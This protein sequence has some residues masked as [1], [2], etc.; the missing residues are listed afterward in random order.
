VAHDASGLKEEIRRMGRGLGFDAVGF[1]PPVLPASA[2]NLPDWLEKGYQAGMGYM[3]RHKDVCLDPQAFFPGVRTVIAVALNYFTPGDGTAPPAGHPAISRYA[4]GRD[5]H[6]VLKTK[7][8]AFLERIREA[9]PG[10]N[11]KIAVDTSPVLDKLWAQAAGLGWQG[12]H[13]NLITRSRGSWVFLGTVWID[14]EIAPDLP[15]TD[16]CGS[17]TACLDACPTAAFPAPYVLDARRCISYWT[18]EHR[19]EFTGD[20]PPLHGWLFGCDV[21]Q[22]VCPWNK[23]QKPTAEPDFAPRAEI[24]DL[25][26]D[27]WSEMDDEQFERVTRGS[28]LRRARKDGLRRNAH[29]LIRESGDGK[30]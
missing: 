23:F 16:L 25:D 1:A 2:Q 7:L 8:A 3:D 30:V 19:G 22:D 18:I 26:V 29:R 28:P 9:V 20:T 10:V 15:G 11:G 6:K 21:C 12:K 17:C 27:R 13:T 5:Y 4:R 14:K 24:M